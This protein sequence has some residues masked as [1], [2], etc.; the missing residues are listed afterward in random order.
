M[1]R[2]SCQAASTVGSSPSASAIRG[3]VRGR[4]RPW[5]SR[6][7]RN[8]TSSSER[9]TV[10]PIVGGLSRRIRRRLA[11]P[12][13]LR[14]AR[15]EG[16]EGGGA[17]EAVDLGLGDR[18]FELLPGQRPGEVEERAG[19]RGDRDPAVDG[20]LV[21]RERDPAGVDLGPVDAPRS[22]DVG[23]GARCLADPP[24]RRSGVVAEHRVRAGREDRRHPAS[25]SCDERVADRVHAAMQRVQAAERDASIDRVTAEAD[26]RGAA[27]D[28]R[29]RAGSPRAV[30][31]RHL[32]RIDRRYRGQ[33]SPN[34]SRARWWRPPRHRAAPVCKGTP[35]TWR[36][37]PPHRAVRG[38]PGRKPRSE[39]ERQKPPT[40][41]P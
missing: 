2:R 4:G 34:P 29:L 38:A 17:S 14:V 12:R 1:R 20:D 31:S 26:R 28:P 32:R 40:Q 9:V 39:T 23:R 11:V 27:G 19:R 37:P 35:Q 16:G 41:D 22:D 36:Q 18:R 13:A 24:E 6:K 15:D 25:R 7:A 21:G 10:R 8:A 33:S 30:P 5:A 3:F